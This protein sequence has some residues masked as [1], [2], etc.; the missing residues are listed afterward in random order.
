MLRQGLDPER[1]DWLSLTKGPTEHLQQYAYID[2]ALDPIPNGGCT[3]TCEALWMG[4]PTYHPGGISLRQ[5]NEYG[6]FLPVPTR[7]IGLPRI[8]PATSIWRVNTLPALR[9]SVPTATTGVA[10][11]EQPLGDAADLMHHLE[12]AF[13]EMHVECSAGPDF[14][15]K[16]PVMPFQFLAESLSIGQC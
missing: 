14:S 3:T 12:A 5:S 13:S 8:V 6:P 15:P 4:V 16:R 1:V 11:S 2:I 7:P 9:S 10:A